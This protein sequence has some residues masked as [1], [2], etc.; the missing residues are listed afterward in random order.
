MATISGSVSQRSDAYSFYIEWS[1]SEPDIANNTRV[2]SATAYIY[3][4][5]HTAWANGLAQKL[6]I[7][8][9]E[10]TAIKN[11]DLSSG[12]TV[13]LVSGSKT[14][15]HNADGNKSITI[16]AECDLPDGN[17]YGP[18]WGS[19]SG[20]AILTTI[21]R[22][23]T[24]Y[25]QEGTKGSTY[26]YINWSTTDVIDA[27]Q[28][29]L[30]GG[31]WKNASM[32]S[33]KGG[34]FDVGASPATTYSVKCRAKRADSQLWTESSSIS[35]RTYQKTIPTISL[36]SK[37]VNSITVKSSCNVAVSSTKYRIKK[38]GGSYGSYQTSATFTGLNPNTSYV[39]EVYN[40]GKDSGESGTATLSVTTYDIARLT[41]YPNFNLGDDVTVK[42]TNPSGLPVQVGIYDTSANKG[43]APYRTVSGTSYTFEFTDEELD[44]MYKAINENS[45]AVRFYI[46]TNAN[47][48]RE[49]KN[50][51]VT[52]TGN[53][54]TVH[55]GKDGEIKRGK[56][57]IARN[58]IKRGVLWRGVNGTA[59]RC[60]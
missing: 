26:F 1:E 12:V 11:V 50:A 32:N 41:S 23:T 56:V 57:F 3:C 13:S 47:A 21:P 53:Q 17:G 33:N 39:I 49:Y 31:S 29:S 40:T 55:I 58:G 2:V 15:E 28:Y 45:L 10:F 60:I 27:L 37:S 7:D 48:Y 44:K 52:L 8:G 4:S 24:L 22:Y 38:S 5:K 6:I 54:K 34:Y 30:N 14:I 16:S 35:I 9:T 59:R 18:V 36:S 20:T 19:A 25:I 46:N 51:T 43:Y 42:F